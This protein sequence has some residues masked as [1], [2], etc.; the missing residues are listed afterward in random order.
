MLE[1]FGLGMAAQLSLLLGGLI[2]CWIRVPTR[3]VGILAGLGAGAM[4]SAVAF[5]LIPEAQE[6]ISEWQTVLW[7]LTGVAIFMIG[8]WLVERRFGEQGSGDQPG[9]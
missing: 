3:V 5:D 1:A 4:I 7:M 8:D 6:Q 2:V 9:R